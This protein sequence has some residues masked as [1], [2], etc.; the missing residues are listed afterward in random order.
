MNARP[1]Q[2][3]T[4]ASFDITRAFEAPLERVW[5]AWSD[6]GQLQR[7]WGPSGCA[8]ET[9]VFDFRPGG[10]FHYA[11]RFE[12]APVMWGRFNYRDIA[13]RQR[14]VWL[15]SFAN[16]GGGIARAPFSDL[17][18]LEVDNAVT[19]TEEA[20][21]TVVGLRATPFGA[22]TEEIGYFAELCASGS[23]AQGYGA[24][25]DQLGEHLQ[26]RHRA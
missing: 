20:G 8:I 5:S 7:W 11:M 22:S 9:K 19:F 13:P 17:C 10:F 15:N 1:E 23:L 18:P 4:P 6:A 12:G 24:S 3:A 26:Q 16:E 14:I 21:K 25:L 2:P